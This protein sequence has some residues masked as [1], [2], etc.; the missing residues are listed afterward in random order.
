MADHVQLVQSVPEG[1]TLALRTG[2]GRAR[3]GVGQLLR[4]SF[5]LGH[6]VTPDL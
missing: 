4:A 3:V 6:I 5:R 1:G 2:G